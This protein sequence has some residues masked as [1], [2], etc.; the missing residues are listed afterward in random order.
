MCVCVCVCVC[1]PAHA[2][3][4]MCVYVC[5][6]VSVCVCVCVCVC[7]CANIC[8]CAFMLAWICTLCVCVCAQDV[9]GVQGSHSGGVLQERPARG[10]ERQCE[11]H[12]QG[13]PTGCHSHLAPTPTHFTHTPHT[14][15]GDWREGEIGKGGGGGG[16]GLQ[17]HVDDGKGGC[18]HYLLYGQQ[19]K[20]L[21][22]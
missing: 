22:D 5:V 12:P 6:R 13:Q 17:C 1:A 9:C 18:Q 20:R 4:C 7:T 10:A 2:S 3:T 8:V 15:G 19:G 11:D 14:T 21:F 16:R